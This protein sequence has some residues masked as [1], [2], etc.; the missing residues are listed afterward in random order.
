MKPDISVIIPVYNSSRFIADAVNSALSQTGVNIEALVVDDCSEDETPEIVKDL[1]KTDERLLYIRTLSK[2]GITAA[3][4][5]GVE[6]AS[7]E[8]AA[9]LDAHDKWHSDKLSRQIELIRQYESAGKFPPLC[10]T[11]AYVMNDDGSFAGRVIK[12]PSRVSSHELL[13]GNVILAST[14]MVRRNCLLEYP[15]E[16]GSLHEDY[17]E[18]YRILANYGAGIGV[19]LPL[20]R[21]RLTD[22]PNSGNKLKSAL[23]AW[24]TYKYLGLSNS[25]TM[26][27]FA[28]YLK[29][30]LQRYVY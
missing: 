15:F 1:M 6:A 25:Q 30:G 14:A 3:R 11:G 12:A 16:K 24:R 26:V 2:E 18:W 28:L 9:F 13:T 17:I 8:W 20:V 22:K 27:S 7:G 10:Y 29:N 5:T 21:Y 4:N 19:S 23:T